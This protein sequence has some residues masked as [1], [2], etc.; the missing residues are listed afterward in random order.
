MG[1]SQVMCFKPYT[2]QLPIYPLVVGHH[3]GDLLHPSC[4]TTLVSLNLPPKFTMP[5]QLITRQVL[6]LR[7]SQLTLM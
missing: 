6:L 3:L 2:C 7:Q 1:N 5:L 4:F